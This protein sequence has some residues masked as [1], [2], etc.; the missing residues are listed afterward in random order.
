M[1]TRVIASF[2][3]LFSHKKFLVFYIDEGFFC[4]FSSW[5][6]VNHRCVIITLKIINSWFGKRLLRRI[7][8]W[9]LLKFVFKRATFEHLSRIH[10]FSFSAFHNKPKCELNL[11]LWLKLETRNDLPITDFYNQHSQFI[12][13][14]RLEPTRLAIRH[15]VPS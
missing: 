9:P 15:K 11:I 4:G 6:R 13:S 1:K 7:K 10:Q 12:S 5:Y 8:I 14:S 3:Q 2:I